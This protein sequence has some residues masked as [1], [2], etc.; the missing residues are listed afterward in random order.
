MEHNITKQINKISVQTFQLRD[1]ETGKPFTYKR[2]VL[3]FVAN[4][5]Q[6]DMQVKIDPNQLLVLETL[7]PAERDLLAGDEIN[8]T[9]PQI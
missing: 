2:L 5:N 7:P 9:D 1:K 8:P 4:G 3:S 6:I